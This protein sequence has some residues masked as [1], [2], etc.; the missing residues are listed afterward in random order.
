MNL[1]IAWNEKYSGV[2]QEATGEIESVNY[3]QIDEIWKM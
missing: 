2:K 1:E 3:Q